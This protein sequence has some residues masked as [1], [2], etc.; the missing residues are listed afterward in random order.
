MDYSSIRLAG[1]QRARVEQAGFGRD[2][3]AILDGAEGVVSMSIYRPPSGAG[4]RPGFI[5]RLRQTRARFKEIRA[6]ASWRPGRD[7]RTR[8][9]VNVLLITYNH[10]SY[11]R[12][13]IDGILMQQGD[14]DLEV[15]IVDDASTDNTQK[16]AKDYE[17]Q[18]A[19]IIQ[20]YFNEEN[21]GHI[22]TQLNTI[23]GFGLLTGDY[24]A[25]L[26][27]DD[28]WTDPKKLSKQ[29]IFLENNVD[30]VA[31]G[32][33]TLKI[34][35]DSQRDPEHFLPFKAFARDRASIAD[36]IAMSAVFHLSS[37]VYRNV[38]GR[39]PPLC[40]ADRYSCE[41]MINVVYGQFGDFRYMPG[42]MS[43]YRAH[44]KGLFST[45]S[46]EDIWRFHLFGYQRFA[47]YMGWRHLFAFVRSLAGFS[48]YVLMAHRRGVGPPLRA[49]TRLWFLLYFLASRLSFIALSLFKKPRWLIL[50]VVAM[51]RRW[52]VLGRV[53]KKTKAACFR[54][55][56]QK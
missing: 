3:A 13:A 29:L 15:D 12:S 27:G 39:C 42:Y 35:Q 49:G 43:V 7:G 38:F 30:Y 41:I 44:E 19:G 33:D 36:L 47:L 16:I 10:Q 21:V 40:L 22:A 1:V 23:R 2:A 8:P 53:R 56:K 14:F 18:Y 45:R 24:F 4:G 9:K 34:Y 11:I 46:Q 52:P 20:C 17:T 55:S 5:T 31:C 26:E 37:V 48:Q 51:E 54:G 6:A 25:I 32:H 50:V 28:Y